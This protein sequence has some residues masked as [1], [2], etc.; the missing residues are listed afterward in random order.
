MSAIPSLAV[1]PHL[2]AASPTRFLDSPASGGTPMTPLTSSTSLPRP[3]FSHLLCTS[4]KA[5]TETRAWFDEHS[6]YQ[7][8]KQSRVPLKLP[9]VGGHASDSWV[10]LPSAHCGCVRAVYTSSILSCTALLLPLQ[11]QNEVLE[12]PATSWRIGSGCDS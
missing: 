9:K 4:L 2:P 12:R 1:F 5:T 11:L 8:V 7:W 10:L 3:S 6:G